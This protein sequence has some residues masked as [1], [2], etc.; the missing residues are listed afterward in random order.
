[1]KLTEDQKKANKA[2]REHNKNL[3]EIIDEQNQSPVKEMLITI[4]WKRSRTWGANPH[5]QAKISFHNGDFKHSP[6]YTTSGCGYDKTSTVVADVFNTYMKYKLWNKFIEQCK[7]ADYN[8]K[9]LGGAP[10]GINAGIWETDCG[11]IEYRY[12]G[13]GIGISCY[14]EIGEF[15]GGKFETIANGKT[16]DVFKYIDDENS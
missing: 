1:M 15:I 3:Q 10:Y 12:F 5:C 8:W 9:E 7:R 11:P 4:E 2:L 6:I 14:K 16:F 13:G